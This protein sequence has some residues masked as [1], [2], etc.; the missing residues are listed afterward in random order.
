MNYYGLIGKKLT[1]SFS[2]NFFNNKFS[3]EN[4]SA[5]YENH[6]LDDVS[7]IRSLFHKKLIQGINV[8]VPYKNAVIEFLDDLDPISKDINA[9]NTILPKYNNGNLI[10]L[11]GYNTDV[12]GFSQMIK[13]Y[14]KSH[15]ERALVLGTGGASSAVNYVLKSLNVKVNFISRKTS[16][17][18]NVFTWDDLNDYMIKHHFL[19]INTTPVGMYPNIKE[20]FEF[21]FSQVGPKHLF[22]DLIYNPEETIFL[23]RAR[24]KKAQTLN[25]YNMLV[26]QALKAWEIWNQ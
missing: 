15:H 8:T 17:L 20:E 25:G 12:Y 14:F 18:S 6:E 22:I 24:L 26:N 23:K 4:I 10:S 2:Q 13:P 5:Y 3:K 7:L 16:E 11:K 1:H 21:P 9:V 19:V